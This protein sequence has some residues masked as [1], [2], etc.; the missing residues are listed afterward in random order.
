M[1]WRHSGSKCC[2]LAQ[3]AV[4]EVVLVEVWTDVVVAADVASVVLLWL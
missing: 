2:G 4:W 1:K 3:E